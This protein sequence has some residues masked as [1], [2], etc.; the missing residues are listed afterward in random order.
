MPDSVVG[1]VIV[2]GELGLAP[3]FLVIFF[4]FFKRVFRVS[5][6]DLALFNGF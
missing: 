1:C 6:F 2:L 5:Y 3:A 4:R